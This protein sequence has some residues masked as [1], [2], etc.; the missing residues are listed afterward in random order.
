[1]D[2]VTVS[3]LCCGAQCGRHISGTPKSCTEDEISFETHKKTTKKQSI[4]DKLG[5]IFTRNS[6]SHYQRQTDIF[7]LLYY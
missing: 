4:K 2:R 6:R 7:L 1:M 3:L 5:S